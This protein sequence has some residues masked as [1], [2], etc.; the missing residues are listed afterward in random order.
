MFFSNPHRMNTVRCGSKT[1]AAKILGLMGRDS[2]HPIRR[3]P[4]QDSAHFM[5][6]IA[7]GGRRGERIFVAMLVR[8]GFGKLQT[9]GIYLLISLALGTEEDTL[10]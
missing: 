4:I 5:V 9:G 6:I 2:P 10:I 1:W 3:C 8:G 7:S